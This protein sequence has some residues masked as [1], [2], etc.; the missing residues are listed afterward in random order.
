M[1]KLFVLV[2]AILL[3]GSVKAQKNSMIDN[4]TYGAKAGLNISNVNNIDNTK[5]KTSIHLGAFA[6]WRVN[7]F[8]GIQPE[9]LYSRQGMRFEK[10]D[11]WKS[12]SRLNYLN[13]PILARLY[14]LPDLSVDL[15]P[16]LAFA[17]NGKDKMKKDGHT[18][19][20]KIKHL[21]AVEI[22]FAIGVSY[23]WDNFIFS[24]RYNLGL[25]NAYDKDWIG[26]NNKNHVFQLSVG[27]R[28]SDLF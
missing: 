26:G 3:I 24:G 21:N 22:G 13:I 4:F 5:N 1:K 2:V 17:L 18:S 19:T 27:Y 23:N 15:G 9:L 20:T 28:L 6:E 8:F 16:Q 25:S 7:D 10:V 14:V 11:G 12:K